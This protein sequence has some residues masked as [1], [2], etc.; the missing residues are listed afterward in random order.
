MLNQPDVIQTINQET[1]PFAF[2]YNDSGFPMEL[3]GLTAYT[4]SLDQPWMIA[5]CAQW[6]LLNSDGDEV[7]GWSVDGMYYKMIG[8][9]PQSDWFGP[10]RLTL[11]LDLWRR[12]RQAASDQELTQVKE[13]LQQVMHLSSLPLREPRFYTSYVICDGLSWDWHTYISMLRPPASGDDDRVVPGIRNAITHAIGNLL[14]DDTPLEPLA[15]SA[16]T[17]EGARR[18]LKSGLDPEDNRIE[19]GNPFPRFIRRRAAEG[20]AI[21][22]NAD[23]PH[24]DIV[25]VATDWWA[26]HADDPEYRVERSSDPKLRHAMFYPDASNGAVATA[27]S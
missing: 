10:N 25:R 23:W 9:G 14:L 24:A 4:K 2:F 27:T 8:L 5:N 3:P 11:A 15:V 19:P 22:T 1:H 21:L 12:A 18:C 20:L 7:Y 26:K 16:F 6:L 17:A 13:D